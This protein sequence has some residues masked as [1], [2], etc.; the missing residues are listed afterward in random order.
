MYIGREI[1]VVYILK[2]FEF[3]VSLEVYLLI[4]NFKDFCNMLYIYI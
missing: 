2:V 3:V 1:L 4:K